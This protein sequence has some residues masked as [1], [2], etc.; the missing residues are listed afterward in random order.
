[1]RSI[2]IS[3]FIIAGLFANQLAAQDDGRRIL[4]GRVLYRNSNVVNEN[5]INTTTEM[6]T[7][8]NQRGDSD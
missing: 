4:R 6:A 8:T 1:M 7:I 2:F 3:L 5:V